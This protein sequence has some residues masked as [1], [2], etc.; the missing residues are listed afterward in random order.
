LKIKKDLRLYIIFKEKNMD[1]SIQGILIPHIP[2][3]LPELG[4]SY[5]KQYI[6]NL[7]ISINKVKEEIEKNP[8]EVIL[9]CSPHF[10]GNAFSIGM[11]EFYRGD[12]GSFQRPDIVDQRFGDFNLALRIQEEGIKS[13][14]L[15]PIDTESSLPNRI[16]Y[17]SIVALKLINPKSKIPIIPISVSSGN[18]KEHFRWGENLN[19]ICKNL[20]KKALFLASTEL[21]Q[22]FNDIPNAYPS[23][24][25]QKYDQQVIDN[26]INKNEEELYELPYDYLK[27][28]EKELRPVY[29][30]AGYTKN[31]Q[32]E[33]VDYSGFIGCGCAVIKFY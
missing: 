17:G 32:G 16:D 21:A 10:E 29:M 5:F 9:V 20:D 12:L 11:H 4:G 13:G 2:Y 18:S 3:I 6:N 8:P 28:T 31:L 33:L 22:D 26:L 25:L 1:I 30:L 7:S 15:A 27:Y 24:S 19:N 14:Y 23:E